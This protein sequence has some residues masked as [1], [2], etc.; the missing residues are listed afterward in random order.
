MIFKGFA[1]E[2]STKIYIFFLTCRN[3]FQRTNSSQLARRNNPV[4]KRIQASTKRLGSGS[5]PMKQNG[6]PQYHPFEEIAK[7]TSGNIEDAR[8]TPAETTR[9][10]IEVQRFIHLL[11]GGSDSNK[12]GSSICIFYE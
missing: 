1:R 10:I 7:A 2:L 4:K 6:K 9:T 5:D 3:R 11:I 8:L 12:E